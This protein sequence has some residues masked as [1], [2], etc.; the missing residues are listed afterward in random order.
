MPPMVTGYTENGLHSFARTE[1]PGEVTKYKYL[2]IHFDF[3]DNSIL[4]KITPIFVSII[5]RERPTYAQLI[6]EQQYVPLPNKNT[7][8]IYADFEPGIYELVYGFY[9][10]NE[11]NRSY[12][13]FYRKKCNLIIKREGSHTPELPPPSSS[14]SLR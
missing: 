11:V 2:D 13:E 1:C 7:I 10:K 9:F 12:P 6:F 4:D 14:P 5:K 8:R 3:I